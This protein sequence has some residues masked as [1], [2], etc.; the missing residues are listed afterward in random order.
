MNDLRSLDKE[1]LI[2]SVIDLWLYEFDDFID[3]KKVDVVLF[4][5]D[6]SSEEDI[7]DIIDYSF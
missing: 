6:N 1:V 4:I 3:M 7:R 2:D 5:L